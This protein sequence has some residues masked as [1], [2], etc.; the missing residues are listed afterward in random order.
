M[1]RGGVLRASRR[2]FAA[3]SIAV[4]KVGMVRYG[5]SCMLSGNADMTVLPFILANPVSSHSLSH[6]LI[7]QNEQ[8]GLGTRGCEANGRAGA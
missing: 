1:L 7:G 4:E 2:R 5:V 8:K 3:S 6:F